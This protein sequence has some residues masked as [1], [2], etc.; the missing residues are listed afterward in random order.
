M[1]GV[2][3]VMNKKIKFR[4]RRIVRRRKQDAI[5][6]ADN[7]EQQLEKLFFKRLARLESVRRF[8]FG[9]ISLIVLLTVSVALQA[10]GLG[11]YYQKIAPVEGGTLR[12][13]AVGTFS[14]SNPLYAVNTIDGSISK[15]V[16]SSLFTHDSNN[17]LVPDLADKWETDEK[18]QVYKVSLRKNIAWHDKTPFTAKDVVFTYK[19]IQKPDAK[20]PLLAS[21]LGVD[22]I[23]IDDYTV[24]FSLPSPLAAFPYSL[25]SGIVPE[26]ILGQIPASQL[27]SVSFNTVN[28]VGT[29]PFLWSSVEVT[30]STRETR[31]EQIEL[32]RNPNYHLG[33]PKI[34]KYVLRTFK[35]ESTLI[36]SYEKKELTS[37]IGLDNAPVAIER[38]PS[39]ISYNVPMD[40]IVMI[41]LNNSSP[42]F[43]DVRVRQALSLGTNKAELIQ[44]LGFTALTANSPLLKGQLGYDSALTQREY[45][46]EEAGR[47]LD[48]AG[49]VKDNSDIRTKNG[50]QLSVSFVSQNTAEYSAISQSLQEQWLALGIVM[51]V[52]LRPEE[53]MQGDILNR[54]D[55]DVLLYGISQGI[56]PDVFAYWHSSQ[57]DVR[58]TSRLNLSEYK[59]SIADKSLEAGRTRIEPALRDVKYKPFLQAW[60]DDAPAI[61]LYQPRLLYIART[62][63][64]GFNA[65]RL[66]SAVDRLNNIY[67]WTVVQDT[68]L[69]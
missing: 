38:D 66:N 22:V 24:Q 5:E 51:D 20:S 34:E 25:I 58:S 68:V 63:L 28:P 35:D 61:A 48:A 31:S 19:T 69:K 7:A 29:G 59:S 23:A 52:K 42:M 62:E 67:A 12:E 53:D 39:S 33:A 46:F 37:I 15:L 64:V 18:G 27:R 44:Q 1:V 8:V 57:A 41:F 47:L 65:R 45:N 60:K 16:F 55:Y 36:K 10:R 4:F 3:K 14:N 32:K 49:W 17:Q 11:S 21:W 26:H 43:Q 54:H 9:W 6:V 2:F 50:I 56:D 13:G 40:G 30:G